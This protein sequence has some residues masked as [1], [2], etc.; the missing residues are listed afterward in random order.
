MT[1]GSKKKLWVSELIGND[2]KNWNNE[3]VILDCGTGCGKSYFCVHVLGNYAKLQRK[4]ILYL[5]NRRKLRNQIYDD[6]KRS[7]L[8]NVIYVTTYQ[9]LQQSIQEGKKLNNYDYIVADECHYFTTD[10]TFNDYT[11]VSYN[12]IMKQKQ[13]VILF[14]SA[15]AKTYFRYLL[16]TNK[17]KKKNYYRLDKDYSYVDKVY[18]Y[19][20]EELIS[21]IDDI[22]KNEKDSKIVV[23]CNVGSR[24]IDMSKVYKDKAH[25]Y[26]S[27]STKDAKLRELCGWNENKP[28]NCIKYYSDELTTFEKRILFTTSVLDNGVDLKDER[29]KHIFTEIIDIDTMIQ[30][31]GRKRHLEG[32]DDTCT[33]YIREYQKKGIQGFINQTKWQLDPVKLYK[34]D[35]QKFYEEYGNGKKRWRLQKNK[36]FYSFFKENKIVGQVKINECKYRK[37]SQDYNTF[38]LMKEIGHIQY[39]ELML[40][41]ELVDK[42]ETIIVN[43]KQMDLFLEFLKSLEGKQLYQND[44]NYIK[45]EFETIGVKLRYTGINTFNGALEDNYKE[46]YDCRFYSKDADGNILV[47]KRRKLDNGLNNP[48]RDKT[49]WI[50]KKREETEPP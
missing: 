5:C 2:Y 23:F 18:Y 36:I 41:E 33:F 9:L 48:N 50:L 35:Y 8:R 14:V 13:S 46:L 4:K 21:I 39:L 16:D 43:V 40:A 11:D 6:V 37:Y 38:S 10:A 25:Y 24:I 3:F 22:L 30:S 28:D 44:R 34:E 42:S 45:E 15:T 7:G 26:C 27:K 31:L 32:K 49:Y 19:Q 12:Y 1:N 47:D 29:I 20:G 17:V